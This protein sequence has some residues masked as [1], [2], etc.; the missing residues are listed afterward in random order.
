MMV[1]VINKTTTKQHIIMKITAK[2][3]K[4]L[5]ENYPVGTIIDGTRTNGDKLTGE[6]T[7]I[8][9]YNDRG[10]VSIFVE[11]KEG[12]T[13]IIDAETMK[14]RYN[15][16][17]KPE[18]K[19]E[20]TISAEIIKELMPKVGEYVHT[21]CTNHP[22]FYRVMEVS[23]SRMKLASVADYPVSY[24]EGS[25]FHSG[26]CAP[27]IINNTPSPYN[28]LFTGKNNVLVC[29]WE[30][31]NSTVDENPYLYMWKGKMLSFRKWDGK[32]IH[33]NSGD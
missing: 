24:D 29:S 20:K 22:H 3:R 5:N 7:Q 26:Y 33:W 8:G 9:G 18:P 25:G 21:I 15:I 31:K 30:V 28:I 16:I 14:N 27:D 1:C 23:D 10:Y 32:P 17:S 2:Y 6:I 19:K 13:F 12:K 4:E 11:N